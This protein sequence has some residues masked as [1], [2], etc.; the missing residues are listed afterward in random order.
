MSGYLEATTN[1][2]FIFLFI[3][4][5]VIYFEDDKGNNGACLILTEIFCWGAVGAD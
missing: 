3:G 1:V 2:L 5:E 4:L